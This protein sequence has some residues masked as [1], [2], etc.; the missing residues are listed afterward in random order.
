MKTKSVF[1]LFLLLVAGGMSAIYAQI[2]I[3]SGQEPDKSAVLDIN[4]AKGANKN[5]SEKGLLLPRVSLTDASLS[6][7]MTAHVAGMTVYNIGTSLPAV[8]PENR[9]SPGFYYNSGT[10]WERLHLGTA[11]WFYMPSIAIDVTTNGTFT[12]DL[13][14]EYRKQFE[15]SRDNQTPANSPTAGTALV[16]S[17]GAPDPF[18]MI[19]NADGLYYYVT[20]YDATVFSNLS[21][22]ADGKL[23]YTVNAANV[24]GA[25]YMNIVFAVK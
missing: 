9:V 19:F 5:E 6:N 4:E 15:D 24:T 11:N 21:I 7:P 14:L 20:G 18:T 13:F 12:R 16:K 3:G 17:L 25:T 23:T 1:L 8:L 22:T 2:T 10:R